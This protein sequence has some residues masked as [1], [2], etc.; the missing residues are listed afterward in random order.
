MNVSAADAKTRADLEK[1]LQDEP[2][3]PVVASRLAAIYERDG[4]WDKAAQTYEQSLKQNPQNAQIMSRLARAYVDLK[5]P[6][7]AMEMAKDAHKLAPDDTAISSMLGHL[8]FQTGDY[9]WAANLLQD[10]ST[11][12]SNRPDLQYELAWSYYAIG[13]VNEAERTM[14]SAAPT[15]N[16]AMQADAK[17]FLAMVAAAKAP[18]QAAGAQAAQILSAN[19]NYV[20]AIFVSALQADQ[21]GKAEDAGK[22]YERA[23]TV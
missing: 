13:R 11:K 21:Q 20:P 1:R 5:Q 17:Q 8:A 3:D 6:D 4:T 9:T 18:T 15:L 14:Q 2:N 16:T 19:A 10:V 22:L 7:K 12:L 23:L